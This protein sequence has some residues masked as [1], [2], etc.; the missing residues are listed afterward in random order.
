MQ[1][2]WCVLG[3]VFWITP[4]MVLVFEVISCISAFAGISLPWHA[5]MGD[6]DL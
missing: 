2:T 6:V 3:R 1:G 4:R 5:A